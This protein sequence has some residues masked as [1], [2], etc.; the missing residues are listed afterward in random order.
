LCHS[1]LARFSGSLPEAGSG[2]QV[3]LD[4]CD[5]LVQGLK[6]VENAT[7]E[8]IGR[9]LDFSNRENCGRFGPFRFRSHPFPQFLFKTESLS[10]P[11]LSLDEVNPTSGRSVCIRRRFFTRCALLR[12]GGGVC[13]TSR[14]SIDQPCRNAR[15]L[16]EL[17]RRRLPLLFLRLTRFR[18]DSAAQRYPATC[19]RLRTFRRLGI[20]PGCR[21]RMKSAVQQDW[22]LSSDSPAGQSTTCVIPGGLRQPSTSFAR[23]VATASR[24]RWVGSDSQFPMTKPTPSSAPSCLAIAITPF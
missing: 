14:P 3:S 5:N 12:S 17:E 4:R 20:S 9:C 2:R 16:F 8:L 22:R 6:H 15:Q 7:I 24:C 18:G 21:S 10:S 1:W 11:W 19:N 23:A 13:Q